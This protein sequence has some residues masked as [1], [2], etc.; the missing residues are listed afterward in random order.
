M[1]RLS[2]PM[3]RGVKQNLTWNWLAHRQ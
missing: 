3:V 2:N 1:I